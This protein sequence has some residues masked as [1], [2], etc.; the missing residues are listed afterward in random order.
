M[1]VKQYWRR[2]TDDFNSNPAE[3]YNTFKPL[4]D[5]KS[6]ALDKCIT[7]EKDGNVI[8][9]QAKTAD[10]FLDYFSSVAKGIGDIKLLELN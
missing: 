3:F 7:L 9:D 5:D 2:K 10:C 6:K 4:P 8:G 1:N